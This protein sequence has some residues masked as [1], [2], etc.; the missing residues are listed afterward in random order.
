MIFKSI[1]LVNFRQFRNNDLITF[2]TDPINNVTLFVADNNV[3][4]TTLLQ[5]FLWCLYGEVKLDND[6]NL[7]N[8]IEF[9]KLSVGQLMEVIVELELI[10]EGKEYIINRKIMVSKGVDSKQVI[11][12]KPENQLNIFIKLENGTTVPES[13]RLIEKLFPKELSD[14]FF[15]DGERMRDLGNSTASAKKDISFAVK[16]IFNLDVLE[17]VDRNISDIL[18]KWNDKKVVARESFE[19][20]QSVKNDIQ[21]NEL[22]LAQNR[23]KLIEVEAQHEK[24]NEIIKRNEEFLFD[25]KMLTVQVDSRKYLENNVVNIEKRI[26]DLKN[27]FKKDFLKNLIDLHL[28]NYLDETKKALSKY[29]TESK[30]VSGINAFAIKEILSR[31]KCICGQELC[32]DSDLHV[33]E[34]VSLLDYL[35]PENLGV[36]LKT[37]ISILETK[38]KFKN[39]IIESF[40]SKVKSLNDEYQNL[41]DAKDRIERINKDIEKIAENYDE[42]LNAEKRLAAAKHENKD[43]PTTIRQ[44]KKNIEIYEDNLIK[45]RRYLDK[46]TE[47]Y[48]DN[49]KLF[50]RIS[51]LEDVRDRLK[52]DITRQESNIRKELTNKVQ[53]YLDSILKTSYKISI[54]RF[55]N[56]S[57]TDGNNSNVTG[58][59][60]KVVVSFAYIAGI[61]DLVNEKII[62]F[63]LP[64]SFPLVMDAPFAKLDDHN[65]QSINKLLPKIAR[66]VILFTTDSQWYGS[67][68]NELKNVLGMKYEMRRFTEDDVTNGITRIKEMV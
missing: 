26:S 32:G 7:A 56:F 41:S 35:P 16:S 34:L 51:I 17:K 33:K 6:H 31:K 49:S 38:K 36:L 25:K 59:G 10:S 3:G 28:S 30:M 65:R 62:S 47:N 11:M 64:E 58:E 46:L 61:I 57:I 19:R 52:Q 63:T 15:F 23:K 66:Q 53:L 60:Y 54:D 42:V 12:T 18:K 44:I 27:E 14:Y 39:S 45:L 67:V 21:K 9:N 29:D 13:N 5:A 40:Q 24:Y 4:K 43:L 1:R 50:K 48:G 22:G 8:I 2:S 20:F 55:Y 68:E 37:L